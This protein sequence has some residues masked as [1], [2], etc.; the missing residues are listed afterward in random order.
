MYETLVKT[1]CCSSDDGR[2]FCKGMSLTKY[3][4]DYLSSESDEDGE[5]DSTD[6]MRLFI[7]TDV[8]R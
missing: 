5:I 2:M 4:K 6:G 3:L 7:Q 8:G 1:L